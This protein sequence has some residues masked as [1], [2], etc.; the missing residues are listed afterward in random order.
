MIVTF[1]QIL[2][3]V[4][5]L[6]RL[7]GVFSLA[8]FFSNRQIFSLSKVALLIWMAG[9]LI[10]VLPLPVSMPQGSLSIL[11]VL[12]MEFILGVAI[13]FT[14]D[15][16]ISGIEFA[17]ALMD[18]QA[19]LSVASLLDPSTGA[20]AALFQ[21][22]LK[23][24][25]LLLFVML[26]GHH[27]VLSAVTNSF[28]VLPIASPVN[29]SE[30]AWFLVSLGKDIFKVAV[31]LS[32]PILLVVFIVDF[33]FGMLNRVAEQ[34]NVFQLGFQL[35]PSVALIIFLAISPGMVNSIQGLIESVMEN[36]VTLM[37]TMVG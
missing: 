28:Q 24:V 10:F 15:L 31:M 36:L 20:N 35:K 33:A 11:I 6:S 18:T 5:V 13:G 30:G 17:G 12:V 21:L 16:L 34:I 3:F 27:M 1:D 2:V 29:M 32:A 7:V 26:D 19:G 4:F 23:W 22:F 14:A 9:L 8:P 37:G 25:S